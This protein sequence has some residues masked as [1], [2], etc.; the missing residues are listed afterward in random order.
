MSQQKKHVYVPVCA[1]SVIAY[2]CQKKFSIDNK[3]T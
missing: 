1:K 2:F 3:L